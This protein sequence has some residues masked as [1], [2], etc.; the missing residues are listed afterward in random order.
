M[1][2]K[3]LLPLPLL[4]DDGDQV[5]FQ[6]QFDVKPS[7]ASVEVAFRLTRIFDAYLGGDFRLAAA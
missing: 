5:M 2:T 3:A 1:S 7:V 6:G 4:P